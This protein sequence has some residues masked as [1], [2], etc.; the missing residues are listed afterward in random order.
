MTSSLTGSGCGCLFL[1]CHENTETDLNLR[2]GHYI[3]A[4]CGCRLY[5]CAYSQR[6]RDLSVAAHVVEPVISIPND[7]VEWL[8]DGT[9]PIYN[10]L[11]TTVLS[12]RNVDMLNQWGTCIGFGC[13]AR[14]I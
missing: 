8:L 13:P 12:E 5:T 3:R 10:K 7:I 14:D 11:P 4:S 6:D 1:P 9:A 2:G